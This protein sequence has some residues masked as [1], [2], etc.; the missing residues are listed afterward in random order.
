MSVVLGTKAC[1]GVLDTIDERNDIYYYLELI[2]A[3]MS[4]VPKP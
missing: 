3:V 2:L 1:S 4:L